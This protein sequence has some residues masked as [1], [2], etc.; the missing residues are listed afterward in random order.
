MLLIVSAVAGILL[1]TISQELLMS[2]QDCML[3][4]A[5][6]QATDACQQQKC[7]HG[8]CRGH[9]FLRVKGFYKEVIRSGFNACHLVLFLALRPH[10]D[11]GSRCRLPQ[12]LQEI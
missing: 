10:Q 6:D 3:Q 7:T 9:Q 12:G 2:I 8:V 1:E 5:T 4:Y 11:D